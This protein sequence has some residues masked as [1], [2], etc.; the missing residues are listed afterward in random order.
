MQV[1]FDLEIARQLNTTPGTAGVSLGQM[2]Q[3]LDAVAAELQDITGTTLL[4]VC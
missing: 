2:Q 4:Q 3:A 1:E